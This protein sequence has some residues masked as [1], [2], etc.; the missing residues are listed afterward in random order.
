MDAWFADDYRHLRYTNWLVV[1]PVVDSMILGMTRDLV[2]RLLKIN[3]VCGRPPGE[4]RV[5]RLPE[6][7]ARSAG[8]GKI[9]DVHVRWGRRAP[10]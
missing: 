3:G 9:R 5:H 8:E 1:M 4:S 2:W 6:R 10:A 7:M